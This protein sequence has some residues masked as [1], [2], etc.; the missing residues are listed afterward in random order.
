MIRIIFICLLFLSSPC[1]AQDKPPVIDWADKASW[2]T[3]SIGPSESIIEALRSSNKK[4]NLLKFGVK[5]I[6]ANV[7][8]ITF[9]HF[10]H[11]ER[12]CLNCQDDG[13]PSGHTANAFTGNNWQV[14]VTAGIVTGILRHKANRHTWKQVAL[15]AI[16]GIGSNLLGN[17]IHCKE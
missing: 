17:L 11:S 12:P 16:D 8:V 9:K 13:T 7:S 5:E 10:I 3:A 14:S 1:Y 4:C 6:I 2:V 15:G